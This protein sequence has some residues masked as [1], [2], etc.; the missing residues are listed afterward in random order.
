MRVDAAF[1]FYELEGNW[2]LPPRWEALATLFQFEG[3]RSCD[4]G[5]HLR[6][7]R[8]S[9]ILRQAVCKWKSQSHQVPQFVVPGSDHEHAAPH[10]VRRAEKTQRGRAAKHRRHGG[11]GAIATSYRL[12]P[13]GNGPVRAVDLFSDGLPE[14]RLRLRS[15]GRV[16][17][18]EALEIQ[19]ELLER[20]DQ[21]PDVIVRRLPCCRQREISLEQHFFLWEVRD[22]HS[23]GVR[24]RVDVVHLDP[25]RSIRV[26]LFVRHRFDFRFPGIGR[27]PVI[28]QRSWC[29][30][31]PVEKFLAVLVMMMVAPSAT[32]AGNPPCGRRARANS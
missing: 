15:R 26:H 13:A 14:F 16:H 32:I 8:A 25:S 2:P 21:R 17:V 30:E 31:R 18:D 10:V 9:C 19:I 3:D 1:N 4:A 29:V 22:H 28:Q 7:R 11:A 6:L 23:I 5:M 24:G 27:Q 12:P 20:G